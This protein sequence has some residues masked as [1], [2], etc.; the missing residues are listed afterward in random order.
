VAK[1][2][3]TAEKEGKTSASNIYCNITESISE[4]KSGM[5]VFPSFTPP[6]N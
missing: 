4:L 3:P 1:A 2:I 6:I 5:G